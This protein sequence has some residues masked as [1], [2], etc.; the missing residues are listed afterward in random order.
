MKKIIAITALVLVIVAGLVVLNG[1]GD[2]NSQADS[3]SR[4]TVDS[5]DSTEQ[6]AD[7]DPVES[8]DNYVEY[9]AEALA[10]SKSDNNVLFFHAD[11]CPTCRQLDANLME[12]GIPEGVTIFQVDYDT[13]SE[14]K[15]KYGI[16]VQH[17]LVQVDKDG[18]ELKTW[19]G[20]YSIDEIVDQLI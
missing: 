16:N 10:D 4:T 12:S 17:T 1:S 5:T 15:D 14:L 3:D 18:N 9:S 13:A 20:S 11:W 6:T 2:D 8:L 19:Y 7:A